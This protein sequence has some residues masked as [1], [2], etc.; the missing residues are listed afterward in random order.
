PGANPSPAKAKRMRSFPLDARFSS[1][2]SAEGERTIN[3]LAAIV[4]EKYVIIISDFARITRLHVISS[5]RTFDAADLE[6]GSKLW[7]TR[8]WSAFPGGPDWIKEPAAALEH[9]DSWRAGVLD[10]KDP[11]P[12]FQWLLSTDGP[13]AGVGAHLANDILFLQAIHP[14]TPAVV[15]CRD[16]EMC[17]SLRAFFPVFMAQ[18]ISDDFKKR[19]GG[20]ANSANP[21]EFNYTSNTNFIASKVHCFR[22]EVARVPRDLYNKYQSQGYCHDPP[23]ATLFSFSPRHPLRRPGSRSPG[24]SHS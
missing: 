8:L 22:R 21:F 11:T 18:W 7:K 23:H 19:C 16:E 2:Y 1:L 14:D 6:V 9:F 4:M 15:L 20:T 5:A 24:T 12:I 13:A 10:S 17:S 3:I